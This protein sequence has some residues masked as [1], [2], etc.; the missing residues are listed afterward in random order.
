VHLRPL[1]QPVV[2]CYEKEISLF[3]VRLLL[4]LFLRFIAMF[5]FLKCAAELPL[6]NINGSGNVL[7]YADIMTLE[8]LTDAAMKL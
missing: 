3:F 6:T 7:L 1:D 4:C 8:S 5:Y 2:K